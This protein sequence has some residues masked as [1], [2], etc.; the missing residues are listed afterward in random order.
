MV[1]NMTIKVNF[2]Q[3]ESYANRQQNNSCAY[4]DMYILK[5]FHLGLSFSREYFEQRNGKSAVTS[6]VE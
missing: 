1:H 3:E 2:T 6:K 4:S 5:S